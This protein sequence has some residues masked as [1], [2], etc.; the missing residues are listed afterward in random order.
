MTA[1]GAKFLHSFKIIRG[2]TAIKHSRQVLLLAGYRP[3]N[4]ILHKRIIPI[5]LSDSNLFESLN[6]YVGA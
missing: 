6:D 5:Y 2:R 1:N 4:W 3:V